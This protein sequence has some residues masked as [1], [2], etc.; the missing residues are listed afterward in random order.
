MFDRIISHHVAGCPVAGVKWTYLS[1]IELK[2]C[3]FACGYSVSRKVVKRLLKGA[4]LGRRKLSKYQTMKQT[5]GRDTQF[6]IIS[7]YKQYYLARGWAVWSIDTKKKELFGPFY[8]AG[9]VYAQGRVGCYDH[10]FSSFATG[11][12]VPYGIYDVG[13]NAGYMMLGQSDDTAQFAL[14]CIKTYWKQFGQHHYTAN[15]PILI[16]ADGGGSNGSRTRLFKQELQKWANEEGLKIRIA[17]FPPYC[18]KYN[19]IEHR[20]FP[21]IT[22]ALNSVML[23]SIDTAIKLIQTRTQLTNSNLKVHAQKIEQSFKKGVKVPD[24]YLE[25][26]NIIFDN[27]L[28]KWNYR[29]LPTQVK[30]DSY[31]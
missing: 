22:R 21:T 30:S 17:H 16:L 8:R 15:K 18:S 24:N 29:V 31:L 5:E 9:T 25:K 10:D 6:K 1:I 23:D 4:G 19:P 27:I 14:C 26:C 13:K 7:A 20:L 2:A 28:G 3:L 11:K 12:M